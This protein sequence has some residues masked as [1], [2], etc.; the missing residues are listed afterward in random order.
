MISFIIIPIDF[1]FPCWDFQVW[2]DLQTKTN[3][4][5]RTY[6]HGEST[7]TRRTYKQFLW[8]AFATSP[9]PKVQMLFWFSLPRNLIMD[10]YCPRIALAIVTAEGVTMTAFFFLFLLLAMNVRPADTIFRG[11]KRK[12]WCRHRW[13][14]PKQGRWVLRQS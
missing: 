6:K 5:A 2:T 14:T 3:W 4:R 8:R 9:L 10:D 1:L 11:W 7:S 13:A 12:W